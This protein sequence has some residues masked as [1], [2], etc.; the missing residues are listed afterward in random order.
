MDD[1]EKR[2]VANMHKEGVSWNKM[3]KIAERST[4]TIQSIITCSKGVKKM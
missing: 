1:T 3:C 4:D 2:L